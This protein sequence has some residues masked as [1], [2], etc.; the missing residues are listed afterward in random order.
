[1]PSRPAARRGKMKG[2]VA[3]RV[4]AAELKS[5]LCPLAGNS[6]KALRFEADQAGSRALVAGNKALMS[7]QGLVIAV[8]LFTCR[9][10]PL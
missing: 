5:V 1:M 9:V 7:L 10:G 2:R 6:D 4:G 8:M 3:G